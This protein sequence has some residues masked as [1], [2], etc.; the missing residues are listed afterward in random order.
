[1]YEEIRSVLAEINPEFESYEGDNLLEDMEI[2]SHDIFN[3]VVALED[4]FGIEIDPVFLKME[5]FM[6][7]ESIAAMI[8]RIKNS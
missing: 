6:S 8:E 2:D 7:F 4:A 3:V 1:M 5:N